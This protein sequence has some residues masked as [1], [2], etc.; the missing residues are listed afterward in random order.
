MLLIITYSSS[1]QRLE[2]STLKIEG[3]L[4]S[5]RELIDKSD[6]HELQPTLSGPVTTKETNLLKF[7]FSATL[8]KNAE[9]TSP[10]KAI[11]IKDWIN[12]GRWWLFKVSLNFKFVGVV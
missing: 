1:L 9:T 7:E 5:I 11:G 12:A 8:M 10:W 6:R 2:T 3:R 4:R